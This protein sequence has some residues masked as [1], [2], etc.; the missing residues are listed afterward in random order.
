MKT[1]RMNRNRFPSHFRIATALSLVAG[2]IVCAIFALPLNSTGS[3]TPAAYPQ[4][5]S[6]SQWQALTAIVGG[7]TVLP[8]TQTVQH[9]FG[10][11]LDPHNGITYGHNMVG[12]D[13]NNCSGADCDVTVTVEIIPLNVIVDGESFN[14]SDV[15]AATL[16]SPVFALNHY[17]STPFATA[18]GA[19]PND[20]SFIQGR[21]GVLS[22]DDAGNPLQLQDAIM[23]AEFN[24]TGASSYHLRLNPVVHDPITIVVP[25][26]KSFVGLSPNGLDGGFIDFQWWAAQIQ[27]LNGNL[28]YNDPTHLPLYLP[29]TSCF[30]PRIRSTAAWS[31][32]TEPP[33]AYTVTAI[34][35][36]RL[37]SGPRIRCRADLTGPTAVPSGKSRTSSQLA[38][39]SPSGR[40]TPLVTI[41]WSPGQRLQ[42]QSTAASAIS[43]LATQW[44]Q[45]G[46]RW[47]A[48]FTFRGRIPMA[49]KVPMATTILRTRRFSRGSCASHQIT[50]PSRRRAIRRTLVA[51]RLWET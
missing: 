8:T 32:S 25:S 51:T 4:V 5:M 7:A 17:G 28:G 37:L 18:P 20:P 48:T 6:G 26:G 44:L 40:T 33:P 11:T 47:A 45:L 9:W 12:A 41:S 49:H 42:L 13:P 19:F 36:C 31:V 50:S 24:K 14:G 30:T 23:R 34:S 29:R 43:R 16:A 38:T 10:S 15:V 35:Q 22:Q 27:T 21:G 2:S 39:S 46:S 3:S 1:C